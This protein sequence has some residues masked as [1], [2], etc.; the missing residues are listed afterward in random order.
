MFD[1]CSIMERKNPLGLIRAYQQAFRGDDRVA[2][3]IKVSRGQCDQESFQRLRRAADD[4]GAI[5]IDG[6]LPREEAYGLMSCCDCYASLH[7]SEGFG[8]TLAEAMLMGKPVIAT[9]YSGNV[10]F[11]W[12]SNSLLVEYERVAITQD[13]P[14][15]PKGSV[16]AEP[17]VAQAAAHMRWVYA[18]QEDARALGGVGQA[19]AT[20]LLSFE[21]AGKRMAQRLH[22]LEEQRLQRLRQSNAA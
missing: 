13:L 5:L 6:V 11:T 9:A 19:D 8:L 21:A 10:D 7:R 3:A 12:P 18:H 4:A 20:R 17:S 14:F 16:W 15:Y 1:M 2:L 22:E